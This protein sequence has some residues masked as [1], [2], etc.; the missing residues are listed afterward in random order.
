MWRWRSVLRQAFAGCSVEGFADAQKQ[1]RWRCFFLCFFATI[2]FRQQKM[3]RKMNLLLL[4]VLLLLAYTTTPVFAQTPDC[5]VLINWSALPAA[6][7]V[8]ECCVAGG[9]SVVCQGGRIVRLWVFWCW[10]IVL[11]HGDGTDIRRFMVQT[12]QQQQNSRTYSCCNRRLDVA[13]FTV[14]RHHD[15]YDLTSYQ[16]LFLPFNLIQ[17]WSSG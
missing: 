7:R 3:S 15:W 10:R 9:S 4:P 12:L 16:I 11:D 1:G 2:S 8:P 5:N 13:H 14:G 6:V 17:K